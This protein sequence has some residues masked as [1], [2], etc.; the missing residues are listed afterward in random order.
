[1]C[2]R[3]HVLR[4][5][6]RRPLGDRRPDCRGAHH[7]PP[8]TTGAELSS[9][10]GALDSP[11]PLDPVEPDD[12]APDDD[13]SGGLDS[14]VASAD[15]SLAG[16]SEGSSEDGDSVALLEG[17]LVASGALLGAV[18]AL[19][20]E[21]WLLDPWWVVAFVFCVDVVELA[22]ALPGKACAATSVSTPVSATLPAI[23][24]RLAS[25]RRRSEL[26]RVCEWCRRMSGLSVRAAG[27]GLITAA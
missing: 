9:T 16:A 11:E 17:S 27:K 2:D 6:P 20:V 12:S 13:D 25:V 10:A 19:D 22:F 7:D 1:L 4:E 26:S 21:V 14:R 5:R 8:D 3:R 18:S 23:S 24:Q 15:G